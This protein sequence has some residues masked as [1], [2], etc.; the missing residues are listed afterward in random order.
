M[1][2]PTHLTECALLEEVDT[3][4]NYIKASLICKRHNIDIFEILMVN[5]LKNTKKGVYPSVLEDGQN[6]F[7][8]IAAKFL[9]C[10]DS[11]VLLDKDLH[12]WN[13][14]VYRDHEQIIKVKPDYKL[15][16]CTNCGKTHHTGSVEVFSK[17]KEDFIAE[18]DGDFDIDRW[19][20]AFS[21]FKMNIRCTNCGLQTDRFIDFETM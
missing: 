19:Y 17:G 18:K 7:F 11:Y 12:G 3:R 10:Q 5:G 13:G 15:W 14:W 4:Q 21:W 9:D 6:F 20:D 1:K 2:I 16:K 8:V